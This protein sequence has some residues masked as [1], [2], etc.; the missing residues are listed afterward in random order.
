MR[1]EKKKQ[2]EKECFAEEGIK[3]IYAGSDTVLRSF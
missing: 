2:T 1:A 3:V